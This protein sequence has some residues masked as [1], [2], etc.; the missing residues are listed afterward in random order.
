[1]VTVSLCMIVKN[2]E[3]SIE[4]CLNTAKY[5]ADEIIIVDTGSTDKT[6][7]KC[8]KYTEKIYD[9]KWI[10][11]FSAARNYAYS[12]ATM[13]YILW[14]DADDI[15]LLA[16]IEKFTQ[17]KETLDPNV[18][19][20]I[21]KY[22]TG[23][24][25]KGE[26]SFS[27]YRERLSKRTMNFKWREPVHEYLEAFGPS[28]RTEIAIT[29]G[30]LFY[31]KSDRNIKIYENLIK[32]R[33]KLSPRGQFY[34]ARELKEHKRWEESIAMFET[35][36]EEQNG[37][38]EDNISACND[39][40]RCYK[41]IGNDSKTIS[42]LYRS[43]IYDIPRAETCVN[44]GFYYE[45]RADYEKAIYWF[46]YILSLKKP[47]VILGFVT[48]DTWDYIPFL[49]LAVCYDKI[50]NPKVGEIYNNKALEIHPNSVQALLNQKYFHGINLGRDEV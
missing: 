33:K 43:F 17:L 45:Q 14:L 20:V 21:M 16:D 3:M 19:F 40:S 13:D 46:E 41:A 1:M 22:N 50:G 42:S 4:R 18:N 44:I 39:L 9:F 34:Y 10:N 38:K 6:K 29:H 11:D 12:F 49:E 2:E 35:F 28:I 5:I 8:K 30:K 37:W 7:E 48:H 23:M 36:L 26:V 47:S 27:Y 32:K 24:D 15:L 25:Y 31:K